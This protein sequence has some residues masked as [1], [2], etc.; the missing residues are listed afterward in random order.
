MPF[1]VW[2]IPLNGSSTLLIKPFSV[3]RLSFMFATFHTKSKLNLLN[4]YVDCC[5]CCSQQNTMS[6]YDKFLSSFN[7]FWTIQSAIALLCRAS[8]DLFRGHSK[9]LCGY[10]RRMHLNS[11]CNAAAVWAYKY[12]TI[13]GSIISKYNHNCH[14]TQRR[15][16]NK[17][18]LILYYTQLNVQVH[19]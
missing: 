15:Q 12:D 5:C 11:T 16:H 17:H 19:L 3:N 14:R 4:R 10:S 9:S 6:M 2:N 18:L 13:I 8:I 7:I 1:D